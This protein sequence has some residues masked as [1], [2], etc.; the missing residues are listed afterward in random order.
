M[1]IIGS[2]GLRLM[3][4]NPEKEVERIARDTGKEL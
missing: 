2:A 1:S 4:G 3:S